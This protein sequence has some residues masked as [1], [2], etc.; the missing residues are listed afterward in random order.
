M[1][2]IMAALLCGSVR[3]MGQGH[4]GKLEPGLAMIAALKP[5]A[6]TDTLRTLYY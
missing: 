3:K 4:E 2:M 6:Q 1:T 5:N